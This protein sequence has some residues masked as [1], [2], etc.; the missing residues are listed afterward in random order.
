MNFYIITALGPPLL[1]HGGIFGESGCWFGK[2]NACQNENLT[3]PN[4]INNKSD[5]KKGNVMRI[6]LTMVLLSAYSGVATAEDWPR[7]R[8]A[9]GSGVSDSSVLTEW[10]MDKNLKWSTELPGKGSSSPIV[11]GDRIYLTSYTGYGLDKEN[12]GNAKDL[13]RHL[14]AFDRKT[15]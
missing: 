15:G 10:S 6:L 13:V 11:F 7:F 3:C 14:I 5:F 1:R 12:P 4:S 2:T 8:G 9:N